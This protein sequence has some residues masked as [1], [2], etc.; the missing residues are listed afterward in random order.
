MNALCNSR[1]LMR[2]ATRRTA[3]FLWSSPTA[4][5][6]RPQQQ[7]RH[8]S[9]YLSKAAKKRLTLTTKRARKG[10][11][12]GN[13]ATKEGRH[14]SKGKFIIDR[15]KQVQLVLPDLTGFKVQYLQYM[16]VESCFVV[17]VVVSLNLPTFCGTISAFSVAVEAVHCVDRLQ[18]SSRG[19]A[20][21]HSAIT[22]HKYFVEFRSVQA[23]GSGFYACIEK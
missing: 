16:F 3:S 9:K 13:G 20:Q 6:L 12:K 8:M 15:L 17:G 14:T 2:T 22:T 5:I 11:Y 1:R 21:S 18:T 23:F 7:Q 10:F 19:A 4:L